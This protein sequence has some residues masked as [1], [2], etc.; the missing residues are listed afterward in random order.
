MS[1]VGSVIIK[2]RMREEGV[3]MKQN[4]DNSDLKYQEILILAYFKSR[5]K[6]YNFNQL[7]Q[8]MGMTYSEME[9][10]IEHLLGLGY[11]VCI[12]GYV[13]IAKTGEKLLEEKNMRNFFINDEN[14]G[15]KKEVLDIYETYI[16]I[17]F[18]W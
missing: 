10:S 4:V 11:L 18:E 14:K 9:K 2:K 5:Y 12:N 15:L 1:Q 6:R 8:L 13:V 16:P 7:T 17:G 3:S